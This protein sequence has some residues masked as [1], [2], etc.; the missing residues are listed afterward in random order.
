MKFKT[1]IILVLLAL[2][3]FVPVVVN[4]EEMII[5]VSGD[6]EGH[7]KAKIY[8]FHG[9][10]CPHCKEA[11]EFFDSIEEEYGYMFE[12]VSYEV[13]G[14]KDNADL[15]NKVGKFLDIKIGGVPFFII[16]EKVFDAGYSEVHNDAIIEAIEKEY[17]SEVKTDIVAD[18]LAADDDN[19]LGTVIV[20]GVLVV[21]VGLMIYAR[22]KNKKK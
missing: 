4:A 20:V 13:W 12:L 2:L 3:L 18:A 9:S 19:I 22:G 16:G 21:F 11:L 8:F 17:A 1:M 10:T 14:N 5:P 7:E 15:M 6:I